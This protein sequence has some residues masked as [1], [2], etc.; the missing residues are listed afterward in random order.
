[1]STTLRLKWS[2]HIV[3]KYACLFLILSFVVFFATNCAETDKPPE[4]NNETEMPESELYNAT[5]V[6]TAKGVRNT[7]IRAEYI[8]KYSDKQETFGKGIHADFY[9]ED[10][11]HTSDVVAD[12]GW[13]DEDGQK[14]EVMGDVVVINEDGT[15]LETESLRWDPST[16]KIVTDDF[17]KVTRGKDILTGYGLRTDQ[18]M[19]NIEILRNVKGTVKDIPED[20]LE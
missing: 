20:E 1:M 10:G 13:F 11:E 15:K 6:F 8:A 2:L 14:M 5:I 17:V 12:S 4:G 3:S 18:K 19:E 16:D 7:V 9:G